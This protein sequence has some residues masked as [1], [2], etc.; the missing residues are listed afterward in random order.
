MIT[1]IFATD[2]YVNV[3][4]WVRE[5]EKDLQA[6]SWWAEEEKV[7]LGGAEDREPPRRAVRRRPDRTIAIA[8][9]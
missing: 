3:W 4:E 7:R 9:S 1:I 6:S 2:K 5:S 8:I